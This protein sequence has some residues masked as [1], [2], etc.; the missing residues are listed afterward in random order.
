M[1]KCILIY[2]L[3]ISLVSVSAQ[4]TFNG[5]NATGF[6]GPVGQSS[7]TVSD[8]GTTINFSLTKGTGGG[9]NDAM[10]IYIDSKTGGFANTGSMNDQADGLRKAISGASGGTVGLVPNNRSTLNFPAGFEADYAI[11]LGPACCSFGGVWELANGGDNSLVYKNSANLLPLTA[12]GT[13]YTFSCA[14][15]DIGITGAVTFK[16]VASY[17]NAENS[18]RSNEGYGGGLPASNVGAGTGAAPTSAT[19]TTSLTY[20]GTLPLQLVAFSGTHNNNQI[21][22]NWNTKNEAGV[23]HFEIER[24][25]NSNV[26][27]KAGAVNATNNSNGSSYQFTV[28]ANGTLNMF[29][30]KMIDKDNKFVYSPVV[31]VLLKSTKGDVQ[32]YPTVVKNQVNISV[33]QQQSGNINIALY[34]SDGRQLQQKQQWLSS[35]TAVLNHTLPTNLQPGMYTI[36]VSTNDVQESKTIIVQ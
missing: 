16:F 5:N 7:L 2:L 13:V 6:G 1:K 22:L 23:S 21:T 9:F 14:K 15:A 8:N 30:L 10:V 27:N 19:Y 3:S 17:L 11:A 12:T 29:R 4:T 31:S 28:Q 20:P 18:F 24:T 32:V 26:W 34:S 33:K 36:R 25:D 35:G